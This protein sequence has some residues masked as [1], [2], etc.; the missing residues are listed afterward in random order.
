M[1]CKLSNPQSPYNPRY[2]LFSAW[3][4]IRLQ[5]LHT[6]KLK[7]FI[8][9]FLFFP[10]TCFS[11]ISVNGK[12][13]LPAPQAKIFTVGCPLSHFLQ[14]QSAHLSDYVWTLTAAYPVHQAMLPLAVCSPHC[15]GQRPLPLNQIMTLLFP[16]TPPNP[17]VKATVPLTAACKAPCSLLLQ[18]SV[19]VLPSARGLFR[20]L[21]LKLNLHL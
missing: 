9:N 7:S 19:Q 12:I 1:H 20:W 11:Y 8:P 5:N 3:M 14:M 16:E 2:L 10:Q 13:L 17:Q 4:S 18:V 6:K 21:Y 15:K